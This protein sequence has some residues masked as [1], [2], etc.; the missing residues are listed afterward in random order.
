MRDPRAAAY[1]RVVASKVKGDTMT[2]DVIEHNPMLKKPLLA[3]L[4]SSAQLPDENRDA[5]EARAF[6]TWDDAYQQ[7]PAVCVD[8]LIRTGALT[9]RL[10]VDGEPYDGTLDDLQADEAVPEDAHAE[11]RIALTDAGRALLETYAPEAT[12]RALIQSKPAYRDVFAAV[13]DAC[14]ADEGATRTDLERVIN[15]FPQLQPDPAT[16]R[17]RVYPQYFIDAL[18]TAGG[19][20]WDGSWRITDTGKAHRA[21]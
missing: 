1:A 17:T 9:E 19:I 3:I 12:L 15:T 14:S 11:T 7:S 8:V 13:L 6:E 21:A 2:T 20:A 4:A 5:V 18:E 10:L 16:Q